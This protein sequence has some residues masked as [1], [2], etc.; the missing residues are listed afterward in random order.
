MQHVD[1]QRSRS[2]LDQGQRHAPLPPERRVAVSHSAGMETPSLIGGRTAVLI[3]TSRAERRLGPRMCDTSLMSLAMTKAER[4]TFLLARDTGVMIVHG[5]DELY[6]MPVW[7]DYEPGGTIG[8]VINEGAR[9]LAALD[10]PNSRIGLTV[11]H[12]DGRVP[13]FVTAFGPV[14]VNR[15]LGPD[16]LARVWP[17]MCRALGGEEVASRYVALGSDA[18][19]RGL[20]RPTSVGGRRVE[21]L[22]DRWTSCDYAKAGERAEQIFGQASPHT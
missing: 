10:D 9:R 19:L 15:T 16:D 8:F 22:P 12:E 7:Y 2:A 11:H 4:D 13:A 5:G 1:Q 6:S 17:V 3:W 20:D 18:Y 14:T 21:M